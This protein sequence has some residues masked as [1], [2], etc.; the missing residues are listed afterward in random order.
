LPHL[1]QRSRNCGVFS[2][3]GA[4]QRIISP[5]YFALIMTC[6]GIAAR[7]TAGAAPVTEKKRLVTGVAR[8]RLKTA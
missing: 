4:Q 6:M 2:F 1:L 8:R 7:P 5:Y 3:Y